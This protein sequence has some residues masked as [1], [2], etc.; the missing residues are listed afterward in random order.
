MLKIAKRVVNAVFDILVLA[1]AMLFIVLGE[2]LIVVI[3]A[4]GTIKERFLL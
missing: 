4:L 1:V 3:F 2:A